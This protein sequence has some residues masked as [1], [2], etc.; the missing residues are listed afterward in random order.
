MQA[1]EIPNVWSE[2][3]H[4]WTFWPG[5]MLAGISSFLSFTKKRIPLAQYCFA[6]AIML[7]T[8]AV[9]LGF[10]N[11]I[12]KAM[13]VTCAEYLLYYWEFIP[14]SLGGVILLGLPVI[15]RT[16]WI[17][18][19]PAERALAIPSSCSMVDCILVTLGMYWLYTFA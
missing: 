2:L 14:G 9:V 3:V 19:D 17:H 1:A 8:L 13:S 15:L 16:R 6:L 5:W 10:A 7:T 4:D 11:A 18:P 12:L